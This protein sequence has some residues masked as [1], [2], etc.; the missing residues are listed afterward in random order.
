MNTITNL[1]IVNVNE[2]GIIKPV[3]PYV[4]A[5][6]LTRPMLELE[7]KD[8]KSHLLSCIQT[9]IL[10]AGWKEQHINDLVANVYLL[11][12]EI[13]GRLKAMT[14]AEVRA[15]FEN[16]AKGYY[17]ENKAGMCAA[18][19]IKWLYSYYLDAKRIEAKKTIQAQQ[20]Q[21][22][23]VPAAELPNTERQAL[24][25][26]AYGK[27]LETGSYH[28]YG[29]LIYNLL[30]KEGL[31]PYSTPEKKVFLESARKSLHAKL[32]F[33]NNLQERRENDRKIADLMESDTNA[34]TEAKRMSLLDYFTKTKHTGA[35]EI[36]F[37]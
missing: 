3:N 29:N 19:C 2:T 10:I 5:L 13:N 18:T 26:S 36:I 20:T 34:I 35:K 28:D 30:D 15:A 37:R 24:I 32:Q 27:Y 21:E 14:E 9:A 12:P 33:A 4:A 8:R 25:Q 6:T 11:M 7:I 23:P 22:Q 16:G 31:L 17:G 1:S